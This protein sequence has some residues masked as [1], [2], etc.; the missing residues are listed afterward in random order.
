MT[1]LSL[2]TRNK[3]STLYLFDIS[4]GRVENLEGNRRNE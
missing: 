3:H 4:I 1:I 2:K